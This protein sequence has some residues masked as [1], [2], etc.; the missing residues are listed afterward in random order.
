MSA[1]RRL[2]LGLDVGTQG[3]KGVVLDFERG[4]VVA[5]ASR[6]YG[7]IEGL[8]EGAAEQHPATWE[9]AIRAVVAELFAQ[10]GVRAAELAGIGVSGQQ[11]GC[12]VLDERGEV[13]RPA[14]LWCDTSTAREAR[15]LSRQLGRSVPTGF[16]AS[17]LLWLARREPENFARVRR[18]LL[19]HEWVNWRFTQRA[20]AEPGD[21]SGTGFFDVRTRRYDLAALAAIDPRLEGCLPTLIESHEPAG[22]L[23]REGARFLGLGEAAVGALVAAGG[24]DNMLSAIGS[25]AVEPGVATLSLGTSATVFAFSATPCIDP[26]GAIAPFCDS[27]GAWLPLLCVMNATAVL[28]EIAELFERDLASLTAAAQAAPAGCD[29]LLMVPYFVGERVPDLPLSCGVLHGLRP[30]NLRAGG[31]FRAALEGV[32][33]NL[34]WGFERMRELGLPMTSVRAVGGGARNALWLSILASAL[35]VPVRP[36]AQAEAGALGAALQARWARSLALGAA[37][38]SLAEIARPWIHFDGAAVEPRDELVRL[39]REQG[40]RLRELVGTLFPA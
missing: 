5:S 25:G 13:I 31:L 27:T 33:L 15:E 24:G 37:T 36:L 11:H 34:A 21:A 14:K 22:E 19:P 29:G 32:A 1:E 9:T 8:P 4:Q 17:K 28:T 6:A 39:Y 12:V 3:T 23:T 20:T 40:A 18:V 16:T 26:Q 35:E 10:P 30:G 38:P 7:L 2:Y